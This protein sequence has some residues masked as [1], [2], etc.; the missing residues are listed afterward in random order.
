MSHELSGRRRGIGE[1]AGRDLDGQGGVRT[2]GVV[3][4]VGDRATHVLRVV[5]PQGFQDRPGDV[6]A[7]EHAR[8]SFGPR[9]AGARS[10]AGEATDVLVRV[11]RPFRDH[12]E[13]S[14]EIS[15][16]ECAEGELGSQPRREIREE[17]EAGLELVVVH[18]PYG[19]QLGDG[20]D[21]PASEG[22]IRERRPEGLFDRSEA[23]R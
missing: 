6:G 10:F 8:D 7:I 12:G 20:P 14:V 13:G 22:G 15:V 18:C 2:A 3:Q 5:A 23:R 4:M 21:H 1:P 17:F 16:Q 9:H 11:V 19:D